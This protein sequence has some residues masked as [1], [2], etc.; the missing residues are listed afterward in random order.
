MSNVKH[1]RCL[2]VKMVR[3]EFFPGRSERWV[4]DKAKAGQFGEVFRD[5]AGW[6]I[7]E[8][9]V[10]GY[11]AR[12]RVTQTAETNPEQHNNLVQFTRQ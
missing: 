9:G 7:P 6:L 10:V 1:G 12:H 4:K 2:S 11:L 3:A 5:D 8:A